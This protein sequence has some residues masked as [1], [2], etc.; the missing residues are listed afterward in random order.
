MNQPLFAA[1]DFPRHPLAREDGERLRGGWTAPPDEWLLARQPA[2]LAGA[3]DAAHAAARA[4]AW[5]LGGLR[6]E[7]APLLNPVLECEPAE[8]LLAA[9]AVYRSAPQD[10]PEPGAER[11]RCQPWVQGLHDPERDA[12]HIEA[13]RAAIRAGDCYQINLTT[14]LL[15]A[16]EEGVGLDE[17]F[18][19]LHAAQPGGFSLFLRQLGTNRA[20]PRSRPSCSLTGGR[21]RTT[22]RPG[23]WPPSR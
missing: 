7:A 9:F 3:I 1:F 13:V 14:R 12:E 21:C 4:G 17:L 11:T 22:A 5:V 19:A 16:L 23:S 8:G 15:S 18:R 6:Y 10:W 20:W 2:E